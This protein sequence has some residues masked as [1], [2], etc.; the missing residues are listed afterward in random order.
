MIRRDRA[1]HVI[2]VTLWLEQFVIWS[3]KIKIATYIYHCIDNRGDKVIFPT[4][5]FLFVCFCFL[6][7]KK[8]ICGLG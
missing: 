4:A 5:C 2:H 3:N 1:Q 6:I 8:V 7:V